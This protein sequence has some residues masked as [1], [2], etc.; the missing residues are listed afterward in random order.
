MSQA[1]LTGAVGEVGSGGEVGASGV[2]GRE[3]GE[4]VVAA[5]RLHVRLG[6]QAVEV[7]RR[8]QVH[9]ERL[10]VTAKCSDGSYLQI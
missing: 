1:P 5:H 6:A 2:A 9:F 3:V 10:Q 7:A 8:R 4:A